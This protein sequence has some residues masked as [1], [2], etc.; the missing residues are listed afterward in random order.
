MKLVHMLSLIILI[1]LPFYAL[2]DDFERGRQAANRG[3]FS[4]ALK[5]W[6][7]LASQGDARAQFSLGRM[8]ARGDG[9]RQDF[10]EAQGWFKLAAAQGHAQAQYNLGR[11]YERGDGVAKDNTKAAKWYY[12]SATQGNRDGQESLN[13]LYRAKLVR[14]EDI[15]TKKEAGLVRQEAPVDQTAGAPQGLSLS[16]DDSFA[17]AEP[18]QMV[19]EAQIQ[20]PEQQRQD[21]FPAHTYSPQRR[22]GQEEPQSELLLGLAGLAQGIQL[23]LARE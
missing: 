11:M 15:E 12:L 23:M 7:P 5:L 4:G 1:C 21:E 6:S 16:P 19:A 9:V 13:R 14:R 10:S 8:Y 18:A 17:M 3:D 2:A 20:V 22:A